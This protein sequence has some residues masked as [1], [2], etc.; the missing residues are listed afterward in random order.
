MPVIYDPTG[1]LPGNRV[2]GEVH[3]LSTTKAVNPL[4]GPFY[5]RNLIVTGTPVGGGIQ[6]TLNENVDY[7]LSP[8]H[9]MVSAVTGKEVFSYLVVTS[10]HTDVTIGYHA[11]GCDVDA[12][13]A[14]EILA[15]GA[16]NRMDPA[17]WAGFIGQSYSVKPYATD[18]TL[19]GLTLTEA[20]TARLSG[21]A[22]SIGN[23]QTPGSTT[24]L[25]STSEAGDV[26]IATAFE[27]SSGVSNSLAM[28]PA[29]VANAITALNLSGIE[30]RLTAAETGVVNLSQGIGINHQFDNI[31][32]RDAGLAAVDNGEGVWVLDGSDDGHT[33]WVSYKKVSNAY[34]YV[35]S[36]DSGGVITIPDATDVVT[37]AVRLATDAEVTAKAGVGVASVTDVKSVVDASTV[38]GTANRLGV[39]QLADNGQFG[40][41]SN[42]TSRVTSYAMAEKVAKR[43]VQSS[44]NTNNDVK[45][46][47]ILAL[48]GNTYYE[49]PDKYAIADSYTGGN[50]KVTFSYKSHYTPV[51]V[52]PVMTGQL[53]FSVHM[54]SRS[55]S[56]NQSSWAAFIG[57]PDTAIIIKS[58]KVAGVWSKTTTVLN[59]ASGVLSASTS[60][61]LAG[62]EEYV[63]EAYISATIG[64]R[65]DHNPEARVNVYLGGTTHDPDD[66][67]VVTKATLNSVSI[68]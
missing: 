44:G 42:T 36:E 67:T 21:L 31:V 4:S 15:A 26:R 2:N 52:A 60:I 5:S 24:G 40:G 7:F 27:A 3:S 49:L 62:V 65:N 6:D 33:G 34:V 23:P 10:D 59:I 19:R 16:F 13:L 57:T 1:E 28:T 11:C 37:G 12:T 45:V 30:S 55:I 35:T 22:D 51:G 14:T 47:T 41:G 29:S 61:N 68:P 48:E 46:S 64:N 39:V 9:L 53:S 20:L 8:L 32:D 18:P 56:G 50:S 54:R 58:R 63:I 17:Q 66:N 43:A 38:T 25:A